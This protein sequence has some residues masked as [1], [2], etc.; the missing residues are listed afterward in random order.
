MLFSLKKSNRILTVCFVM[1]LPALLA[2]CNDK[3]EQYYETT[4]K[5]DKKGNITENIV[6]SFDKDYYDVSELANEFEKEVQ[7]YNDSMGSE[8]I[9]LKGTEQKDGEVFVKVEFNGPSDYQSFVGEEMFIGT[10]DDAVQNGYSMNVSLKGV[11]K[12]DI[13]SRVQ[14]MGMKD[15]N[16][17]IMS[18]P[19]RVKLYSDI[20]YV[21]A[22]VDVV[23]SKEARILSESGGLAY[24]VLK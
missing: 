1:L 20:A 17:V 9:R 11:D 22:N 14:I 19:V 3:E 10:I 21:S 12:G 4:L 15:K 6:E 23:G 16:I 8:E 18:E 24:I 13:I 7:N 2:G 5:I